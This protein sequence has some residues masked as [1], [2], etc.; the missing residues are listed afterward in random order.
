MGRA[1]ANRDLGP[2]PYCFQWSI[3]QMLWGFILSLK[4][5]KRVDM[6]L[7]GCDPHTPRCPY[8]LHCDSVKRLVDIFLG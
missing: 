3:A 5:M 1:L 4:K 7:K 2:C 6:R 8:C